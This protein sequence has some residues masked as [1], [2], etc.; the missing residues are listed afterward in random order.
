[1]QA[2]RA[3]QPRRPR[4][5][6]E[7][8]RAARGLIAALTGSNEA[9]YAALMSA[10]ICHHNAALREDHGAWKPAPKHAKTAFNQAMRAVGLSDDPTLV[11]AVQ[12]SQ[13]P[14]IDWNNGFDAGRSLS[15]ELI[16][17]GKRAE[18]ILYLFLVRILRLADQGSQEQRGEE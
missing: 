12:S 14:L 8:A 10:I 13:Q 2:E 6:T 17:L 16:D 9:L 11:A 7:S 5:A 3:I 4:H 15:N 1:K 18:V